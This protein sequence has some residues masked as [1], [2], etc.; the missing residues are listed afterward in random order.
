MVFFSNLNI[1]LFHTT[2][3]L[4]GLCFVLNLNQ[5]P[6]HFPPSLILLYSRVRMSFDL[7]NVAGQELDKSYRRAGQELEKSW[8]RA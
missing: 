5:V 2:R 6:I 4:A 8:K 3:D 7:A 1:L